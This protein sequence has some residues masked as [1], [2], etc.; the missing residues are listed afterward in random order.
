[1]TGGAEASTNRGRRGRIVA[2]TAAVVAVAALLPAVTWSRHAVAAEPSAGAATGPESFRVPASGS[3]AL[4]GLGFGHGIGMSQFGAEGMGRLGKGYRQILRFYYPGTTRQAVAT[5]SVIRVALSGMT[6]RESGQ[7][8]VTVNPGRRLTAWVGDEPLALPARIGSA[9][10]TAYRVVRTDEALAVRAYADSASLK[11]ATGITSPVRFGTSS[12]VRRSKVSMLSGGGS[13]RTYHGQLVVRR[14]SSGLLVMD[15]LLL[16]H[17]LR[18]V[19]SLEVPGDWT[20][21]AL[22]AQAVAARSYALMVRR[23]ARAVGQRYDICDSTSCQVFGSMAT[24]SANEV[25]AVKATAGQYLASGGEP[26]FTQFSSANGGFS[27]AGSRPYLVAKPDPY[28]GVVTGAANWGHSWER[29]LTAGA[30]ESTWPAVGT[31]NRLVVLGRDGNGSWGGRVQSVAL[32]GSAG[33]VTLSGDAFRSAMGL[34]ST[35]WTITNAGG[36]AERPAPRDVTGTARDRALTVRWRRPETPRAISGYVVT[37][38][39]GGITTE[40]AKSRRKVKVR[41]LVNGV[42]YRARVRAVYADGRGK[43]GGTGAV[44]P[45]SDTSYFKSVTPTRLWSGVDTDRIAAGGAV[46]IRAAG[47]AGVP[48]AGTR[49]VLLRI[50]AGGPRR[51]NAVVWPARRATQRITAATFGRRDEATGLVS[52]P[53]SRRG[54]VTVGTSVPASFLTVDVVGY[55]TQSGLDTWTFKATPASAVADSRRGVGMERGRIRAGTTTWVRITGRGGVPKRGVTAVE[56]NATL[57]RPSRDAVLGTGSPDRP[58]AAG[59][60]VRARADTRRAATAVVPVDSR[61]RIPLRLSAGRSHVVV[62]VLGWFADQDG[63]AAGRYRTGSGEVVGEGTTELAAGTARTVAVAGAGEVPAR[64]EAVVLL[65]RVAGAAADGWLSLRPAGQEAHRR[66]L[67]PF[68]RSGPARNL[69]TVPVGAD[70]AVEVAVRRQAADV[71]LR[72]VGWYS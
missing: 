47:V 52:V 15:V 33:T 58:L 24:E 57:V 30:I 19:V 50:S 17:Y 5:D 67:V 63:T 40:L 46:T 4:S 35:W 55:Y 6:R 31:L 3:F 68:D 66:P 14:S 9:A 26:A 29:T 45:T 7:T 62:D 23:S 27:V 72:V 21:A 10:V 39:P 65:V 34:K 71:T 11:V 28:D 18:A 13:A 56:V 54:R 43:R 70:G 44:V 22:R 53:V 69:V 32:I 61:G 51:G 48:L 12:N 16:E 20:A 2:A 41:G 42:E 8:T 36:A 37:V 64:A 1:M 60:V 25:A 59:A 38:K 49:A